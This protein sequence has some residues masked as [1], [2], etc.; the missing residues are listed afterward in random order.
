MFTEST[1][2][3]KEQEENNDD[4]NWAGKGFDTKYEEEDED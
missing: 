3:E 1:G 2:P 4:K